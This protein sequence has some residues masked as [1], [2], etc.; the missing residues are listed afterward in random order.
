M[1]KS[2]SVIVPAYNEEN[3]L[4]PAV[5][6][7]RDAL[8]AY[9]DFEIIIVN[10]GSWDKTGEVASGLTKKDKR[11]RIITHK[12]NMG[13]GLTLR[14]GISAA[15]KEFVTMFHGDNDTS[16][17]SMKLLFA[18]IGKA[19]FI[20]A[21]TANPQARPPERRII[22]KAFVL[23]MNLLFGMRMKYFTGFFI[24]RTKMLQALPL[25]SRGFAFYPEAKVRLVKSGATY[26]EVPFQHTGRVYGVSKAINIPSVIETIRTLGTLFYDIYFRKT[27]H[28]GESTSRRTQART[29]QT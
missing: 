1:K 21:Y 19:D 26:M 11:I 17:K 3:N 10:D 20:S 22:S 14:D 4:G 6:N 24:C 8:R 23:G 12:K 15:K 5:K 25:T 29:G 7:V 16:G 9:R 28:V 18:N 2:I 13:L 27:E